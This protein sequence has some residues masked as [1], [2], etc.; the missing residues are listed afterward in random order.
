VSLLGPKNNL[1]IY[2]QSKM[3]GI[4]GEYELIKTVASTNEII[5]VEKRYRLRPNQHHF[6]GYFVHGAV[7]GNLLKFFKREGGSGF[8]NRFY[9][10][11]IDLIFHKPWTRE[12]LKDLVLF[13]YR[14]RNLRDIPKEHL[15]IGKWD[16]NVSCDGETLTT[17]PANKPLTLIGPVAEIILPEEY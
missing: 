11:R 15:I 2:N 5:R 13:E 6:P 1:E 7:D 17:T 9:E 4:I 10:P 3:E 8:K 14:L 16:I 12:S